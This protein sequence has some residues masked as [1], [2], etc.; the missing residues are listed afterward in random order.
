[1][2]S[3]IS[4]NQQIN[5]NYSSNKKNTDK[6]SPNQIPQKESSSKKLDGIYQNK[7]N[8][9]ED[10]K[11][12]NIN[13]L[14]QT[15]INEKFFPLKANYVGQENNDKIKNNLKSPIIDYF[16][17]T[18]NNYL[19]KHNSPEE[20]IDA[21]SSNKNLNSN[22]NISKNNEQIFKMSPSMGYNLDQNFDFSPRV[23]RY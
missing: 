5:S 6:N 1:M 11:S 12:K 21:N 20:I 22:N 17:H 9:Q 7:N 16:I 3:S 2:S 4:K 8:N 13:F 14:Q 23:K 18:S 10:K 15:E 19:Q